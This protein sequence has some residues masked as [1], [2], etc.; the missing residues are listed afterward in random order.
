MPTL[1][2]RHEEAEK[3]AAIERERWEAQRREEEQQELARRGAEARKASR[4]QLLA[5]VDDWSLTRSIES[6]FEDAERRASTLPAAEH[7][8]VRDRLSRARA[9][10]GGTN[11]L[12]RFHVIH[13]RPCRQCVGINV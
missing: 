2:Q 11:A 1:V 10:L 13:T 3:A 12:D 4:Q 6:F 7:A 8:A 5:I 9:V